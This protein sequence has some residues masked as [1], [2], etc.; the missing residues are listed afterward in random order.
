MCENEFLI[1][2]ENDRYFWVLGI[3]YDGSN[4]FDLF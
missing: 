1:I 2:L 4:V 3:K